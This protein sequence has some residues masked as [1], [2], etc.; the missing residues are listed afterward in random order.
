MK[1]TVVVA[2]SGLPIHSA[3]ET[4]LNG[5]PLTVP[6]IAF[7]APLPPSAPPEPDPAEPSVPPV[8]LL[9]AAPAAPPVALPD[10]P[11]DPALPAV[12]VP[13]VPVPLPELLPLQAMIARPI[14]KLS[15][16]ALTILMKSSSC[17]PVG[18]AAAVRVV[19]AG[20]RTS[21]LR[22]SKNLHVN[23]GS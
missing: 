15:H 10:A 2:E 16:T 21:F 4:A 20:D 9:P 18:R 23:Q 17:D 1:M 12:E 11:P 8:P 7:P 14:T 3:F 13:D 22:S 19:R 5:L 6:V